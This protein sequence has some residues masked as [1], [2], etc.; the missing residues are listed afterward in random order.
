MGGKTHFDRARGW[1]VGE[2]GAAKAG[3]RKQL[4]LSQMLRGRWQASEM[5]GNVREPET[6][7]AGA[8]VSF[9]HGPPLWA[10]EKGG[11]R[12]RKRA[13]P[14]APLR[15]EEQR[16]IPALGEGQK[17]LGLPRAQGSRGLLGLSSIPHW[18]RKWQPTPVFLPGESQGRG[19]LVGCRLW[20]RT[21]SDTT[22]AT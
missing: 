13:W 7:G 2:D 15:R 9:P 3:G 19:S 5:T 1:V 22:E 11:G 12:S 16:E 8:L 4:K 6:Q 20:G 17:V 14:P 21:E 10:R 18:R